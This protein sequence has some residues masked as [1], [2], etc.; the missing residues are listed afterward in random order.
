MNEQDNLQI[1]ALPAQP[2]K[3]DRA[4]WQASWQQQGQLWRSEPEIDN[5]RQ[6]FLAERRAMQ[7][8]VRQGIYPFVNMKLSRADIEWLLATH[9]N[10]RGPVDYSDQ[11]QRE[12]VG[13]DLRGADLRGVDLHNLPLA[14]TI[15]DVAWREWPD[16]TEEQHILAAIHFEKADLKGA[17]L[18]GAE[19]EYALFD[20]TDLRQAHLQGA[21]L[22]AAQ[23]QRAYLEG[24][25]F[26]GADFW[27]AHLDA[28]FI[29]ATNLAG[30]NLSQVHLQEAHIDARVILVNEQ[31]VGPRMVDAHL[32]DVNLAAINW[33]QV[34]MLGDEYTAR[35]KERDGKLKDR[36]TRLNEYEEAVRANRQLAVILQAQGLNEE[37]ARFAYHAQV[38]Q[39]KL[40]W[41][42]GPQKFGSY[43]FSLFLAML[44]GYGY[45]M[46]R[47]IIVYVV[48]VSI[49]ALLYFTLSFHTP[50]SLTLEQAYILSITAF[51][52]RVFSSPFAIG[53]AQSIVTAFEAVTGFVF[54]GV[55]IAM[56]AQRFFGK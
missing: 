32:G 18:E 2:V 46:W 48:V 37:S 14:R 13:L 50:S 25:D 4:G 7:P 41:L 45:R 53:S 51:H 38:L 15:G 23:M 56:L 16:L 52:G 36:D 30:T 33:S 43:L 54:E 27:L 47:I 39:R 11:S 6:Q 1:Q 19:L 40:L 20:G 5:E 21:N 17:H 8:D 29:W 10:G 24:A 26:N 55:F 28:A 3:D 44:T 42:Q 12:R 22:A 49:F 35:Q 34:K 9:E 31:G